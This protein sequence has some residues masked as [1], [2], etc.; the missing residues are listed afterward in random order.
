V[1]PAIVETAAE[2]IVTICR[3]CNA[4]ASG[5]YCHNCG[6]ETR[7][8]APSFGEFL[9]EFVGHYVALEG[10][11]WGTVG[12]LLFRPG[13]LTN[14]YLAG[15]RRRFVEP[16]RLYLTLSILFFALF[17]FSGT[18][19]VQVGDSKPAISAEASEEP[20]KNELRELKTALPD[21]Y[22]EGLGAAIDRFEKL[23][24]E[25]KTQLLKDSFFR[26][27][28]YAMFLLMP[29]FAAY[30]KLLYLGTGRR[31][32]EH[33]L[34]AL[35]ANSFAFIMFGSFLYVSD[36]LLKTVLVFWLLGYLPWAMQRVYGKSW[37]GT[38]WRW[39]LLSLLHS[40]SLGFGIIGAF[41]MGVLLVR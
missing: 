18:E 19:P 16:L 21:K 24:P 2:P 28:P 3:N 20:K 27:A 17:K 41:G 14:E 8:H 5:N 33:L 22:V 37:F 10:R 1:K 32:G 30:L 38:G 11:L 35:H 39:I 31:Y 23:S 25:A 4:T 15:R 13:A 7:L 34:F 40:L 9:H 6:Q 12:R 26:Y 29:L 36:G